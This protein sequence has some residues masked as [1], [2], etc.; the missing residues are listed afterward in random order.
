MTYDEAIEYD[1]GTVFKDKHTG[2]LVE[3]DSDGSAII[4]CEDG[5]LIDI[6][7]T[8]DFELV[9]PAEDIFTT[10]WE[11]PYKNHVGEPFLTVKSWK[12]SYYFSERGGKDSVAFILFDRRFNQYG[13]VKEFKCPIDKF[14]ITAFGGSFDQVDNNPIN[15]VINEVR[16]E[17]G[18]EV[19]EDNIRS[20]G[21]VFVSTQSNQFCYLFMVHIDKRNQLE[22]RPENS[23]E[24]LA[25]VEWLTQNEVFQLEDW[26]AVTILTKS[27]L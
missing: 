8:Y 19:T 12:N 13:L 1:S 9:K 20:L 24:A 17:A 15:I 16:E 22:L 3:V 14:M 25:T 23:M 5:E 21:K 10:L 7:V 2:W 18:F 27:Y 6:W 4:F 26:K 11:S